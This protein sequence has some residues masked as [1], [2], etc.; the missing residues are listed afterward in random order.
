[1]LYNKK[2]ATKR[3]LLKSTGEG[4]S[5]RR[6]NFKTELKRYL[7]CIAEIM[8]LPVVGLLQFCG[9]KNQFRDNFRDNLSQPAACL[10][11]RVASAVKRQQCALVTVF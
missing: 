6:E 4:D 3:I 8:L 7:L 1:M 10:R 2:S 11:V 9:N 5:T